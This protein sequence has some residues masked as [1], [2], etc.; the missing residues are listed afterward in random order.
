M[1][2]ERRGETVLGN[3]HCIMIK[4][5]KERSPKIVV[6]CWLSLKSKQ[7]LCTPVNLR[8]TSRISGYPNKTAE[9]PSFGADT[10]C[11]GVKG[12]NFNCNMC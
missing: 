7:D 2:H 4:K 12:Y 9:V 5:I 6:G 3:A 8:T 1:Y 11:G 10:D